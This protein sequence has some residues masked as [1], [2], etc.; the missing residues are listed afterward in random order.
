[1]TARL[2]PIR[3]L[4]DRPLAITE[5][6]LTRLTETAAAYIAI[7]QQAA[8]PAPRPRARRPGAGAVAV[9][10]LTGVL[11]GRGSFLTW[12]FGGTALDQWAIDFQD[13][14]DDPNVQ[15]VV[16]L[17]DSP[18]G[19]V[20][21]V[22]ETA[23]RIRAARDVK[24]IVAV[25]STQAASAAYWLAAQADELIVSP[26][27][28]VGSIGVFLVHYD[29][30]QLNA[31][32]GIAP[33]YVYAGRY[34]VE[35][36][37][38]TP[39]SADARGYLQQRVDESYGDFLGAVASGRGVTPAIVRTRFGEGRMFGAAEAV[40]RGM[41][42]RIGTIE[43]AVARLATRPRLSRAAA[44]AVRDDVDLRLILEEYAT[45]AMADDARLARLADESEEL[46]SMEAE[47]A[48]RR[49]A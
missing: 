22:P 47:L 33:T 29:E 23:A 16:L 24:P 5:A 21:L 25:A 7:G 6:A 37:P 46:A 28:E 15:A 40:R 45:R 9:V 27:G 48:A 39:L 20:D 32:V 44:M 19:S 18:G 13:A 30:S 3:L 36:N 34:K 4:A 17:V 1:M 11:T 2:D 31:R 41:A 38:D 12:L 42:D 26:S 14:V 43:D 35:V 10:P 49:T 8:A